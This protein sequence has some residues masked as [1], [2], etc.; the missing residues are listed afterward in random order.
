MDS[1]D[2]GIVEGGGRAKEAEA[3]M[4]EEAKQG[5]QNQDPESTR[6]HVEVER[7]NGDAT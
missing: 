5:D 2:D 3:G 1:T 7:R 6:E 4:K